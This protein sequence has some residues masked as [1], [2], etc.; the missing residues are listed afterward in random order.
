MIETQP[1]SEITCAERAELDA[2]L[3]S[4]LFRRAPTLARIL[5]YLCEGQL[6]GETFIKEYEIAT[7]V[8]GR[9]G[10][11]DPQ[12]DGS[13]RV[14]LHHLR[15]K[16]KQFYDTEGT[17]HSL[18][19]TL[20]IG[21]NLPSFV[22]QTPESKDNAPSGDETFNDTSLT[23]G[24]L[25]E[26][27]HDASHTGQEFAEPSAPEPAKPAVHR[28]NLYVAISFFI[29]CITLVGSAATWFILSRQTH[30]SPRPVMTDATIRIGC[31]LSHPYQDT[32]GRIWSPDGNFHG[33]KA[34]YR[35]L[36]QVEGAAD[37]TIYQTGREGNFSYDIPLPNASYELHLYFAESFV[38]GEGFRAMNITINGKRA[39]Q[40]LDV[41]SDAGGFGIATGKVYTG[42]HPADDG[43]IHL[44][45]SG[46]TLSAFLNA[47]EILPGNGDT[48]RPLRQTT[49][50]TFYF[51]PQDTVWSPDAWFHGGRLSRLTELF[52]ELPLEGFYQNERFGNFSYAIPVPPNRTYS[53]TLY[54]QDAWFS[55]APKEKIST[56]KRRFDVTCNGK[57]LIKQLDILEEAT[58]GSFQVTKHFTGVASTSQGKIL[59]NFVPSQNYAMINAMVIEE[60]PLVPPAE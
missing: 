31:G 7:E 2:V 59:L 21:Q 40:M 37:P 56:G 23:S 50:T 36:V 3:A 12:Q 5:E 54:F 55:H 19:I 17:D 13:V 44:Q 33:G 52:P 8:M 60:E 45:F 49:A 39:E 51:D 57:E 58:S 47:I 46:V 48:M 14:N 24:Q 10:D 35:K 16:L 25:E 32:S 20:P 29:L 34:F 18:R 11:F 15:K 38:H 4:E 41:T 53:I 42:V 9:N 1:N 30:T 6:R 26:T 43:K 28:F 27:I 22:V